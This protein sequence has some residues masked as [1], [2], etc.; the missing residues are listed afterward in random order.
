[1]MLLSQKPKPMNGSE[2][3]AATR[4]RPL[5][6]G[7]STAA[8]FACRCMQSI[9]KGALRARCGDRTCMT[10][11]NGAM[12]DAARVN[13]SLRREAHEHNSERSQRA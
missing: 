2:L 7:G 10:A 13:S 6:V 3:T 5:Q 11:R 8:A 4:P 9:N 1:M 12:E